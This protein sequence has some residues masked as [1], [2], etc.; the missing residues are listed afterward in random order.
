MPN[1]TTN[2]RQFL[3]EATL[4]PED[5]TLPATADSL[6]IIAEERHRLTE[7]IRKLDLCKAAILKRMKNKAG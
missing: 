1:H 6:R 4:H 5:A 2:P 3:I 7:Q